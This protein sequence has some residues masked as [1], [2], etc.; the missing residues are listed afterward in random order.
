MI[1]DNTME[2]D[3]LC[4]VAHEYFMDP[5][6]LP[7]LCLPRKHNL[8]KLFKFNFM[9]LSKNWHIT[10]K[11]SQR[12]PRS[13]LGNLSLRSLTK[14]RDELEAVMVRWRSTACSRLEYI[15]T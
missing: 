13:N 2:Y 6:A 8:V 5:Y 7:Q 9:L 15:A 14:L 12:I 3:A 4:L 10:S 1:V 11:N